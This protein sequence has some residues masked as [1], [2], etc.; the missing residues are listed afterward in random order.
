VANALWGGDYST[1]VQLIRAVQKEF[2]PTPV[3]HLTFCGPQD[4]LSYAAWAGANEDL[5]LYV[6]DKRAF[7]VCP[8]LATVRPHPNQPTAFVNVHDDR[9]H[10]PVIVL[11]GY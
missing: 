5:P 8:A 9:L 3:G 11:R 10:A 4:Y 2:R 6:F 1:E 7:D